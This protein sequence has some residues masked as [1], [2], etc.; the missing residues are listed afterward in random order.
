M[1]LPVVCF[2]YVILERVLVIKDVT[3]PFIS[4]KAE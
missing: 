4:I 1:I 3:V 2:E